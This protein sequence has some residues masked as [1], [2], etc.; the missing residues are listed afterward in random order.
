MV[1]HCVDVTE[2]VRATQE[3]A[4]SE[5]RFRSLADH[6]PVLV[7]M[8]DKN[9]K[10]TFFNRQWLEFTG[11]TLKQEQGEGW[12]LGVHPD[13]RQL[14]M[15]TY[16]AAFSAHQPFQIEFRLRRHDGVY[17]WMLDT[18]NPRFT[19]DG[20]FLGYVGTC[21]NI[22]ELNEAMQSLRVTQFAVDRA[23]DAVFWV[24]QDGRFV[25]V[26]DQAC[27][28]LQFSAAEL[29]ALAVPDVDINIPADRWPS[30]WEG[31]KRDNVVQFDTRIR[32]KDGSEFPAELTIGLI[33]TPAG[34]IACAFARDVTERRRQQEAVRASE[35]RFELAI[36]G[37][38]EGLWDWTLATG[39]VWFSDRNAEMLGYDPSEWPHTL[40]MFNSL[41][42]PDDAAQT[43]EAVRRHFDRGASYDVEFRLRAKDGAY[44]WIRSRGIAIRDQQ[45]K[46]VRMVGSHQDIQDRKEAQLALERT[47][48]ELRQFAYIASHDL[49]EPLRTISRFCGLLARDYKGQLDDAAAQSLAAAIDASRHLQ[50][51][52]KDL[53]PSVVRKRKE[54]GA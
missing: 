35:E 33:E 43:W 40:E 18:G 14:C 25:Y 17:C 21:L 19:E 22:D 31:I 42:H 15:D 4:E 54:E 26:N 2:T 53:T 52:V 49:Q 5:A 27:R 10:L 11:R 16:E 1:G 50:S 47:N 37:T 45:E 23:P 9:K 28:A 34:E 13:D 44:R 32:R 39:E 3:L 29:L 20:E 6:A 38:R 51:L 46:P 8:A 41:L 24:N 7:W 36:Q 48:E 12:A 30:F